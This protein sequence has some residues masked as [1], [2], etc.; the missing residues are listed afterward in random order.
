MRWTILKSASSN[1]EQFETLPLIDPYGFREYD[2]RWKYGEQINLLGVQCLGSGFAT[3]LWEMGQNPPRVVV[4]QD[5]RE[6]SMSV[7]KAL[8][9][10]LLASGAQVYD[11]GLSLTPM[12]YFARTCLDVPGLAMVTASH[13]ENPW[14][15][16]KVGAI[17]PLTHGPDEMKHLKEITMTGQ[18]KAASG[19]YEYREDVRQKYIRSLCKDVGLGKKL[20]VVVCTGNGT[21]GLFAPQILSTIG[22]RVINLDTELDW[23]FPNYNPNP[24]DVVMLRKLSGKVVEENADLGLAFDGDG[25][26]IG[27]VDDHGDELFS[28]KVGLLLARMLSADY[29]ASKFVVDVKSTGLFMDDPVLAHN[30]ATVEYWHTGHSYIKRRVWEQHALAGFEKSGHFFFSPPFGDFYDDG[31]LSAVMICRMLDSEGLSLSQLRRELNQ[32]WQSPTLGLECSEADKYEIVSRVRDYYSKVASSGRQ[33]LGQQIKDMIT[34]NGVRLILE[35]GT[36][37]LVRASSNKPSLIVVVESRVS[38]NEMRGMFL[39]LD[40]TI[41]SV[42]KVGKYDQAF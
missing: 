25:D 8:T 29:P 11:I 13:N 4:G 7:K 42:G 35:Q 17:H 33:V 26:R 10:G 41:K 6:Y 3:Q 24:E 23:R 18:Y 36:W 19:Q 15:G 14:T 31:L 2:A 12:A 34:I 38:E 40:R 27:V 21:A 20:R 5:Y 39:E 1:T 32:T 9:V 30:R 22:C 37:G 28:D 16:V